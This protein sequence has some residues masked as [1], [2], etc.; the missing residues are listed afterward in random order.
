MAA[1]YRL[2]ATLLAAGQTEEARAHFAAAHRLVQSF[3]GLPAAA[4]TAIAHGNILRGLAECALA[5]RDPLAARIISFAALPSHQK[6]DDPALDGRTSMQRM[7]S[8]LLVLAGAELLLGR[9]EEAASFAG[10][11]SNTARTLLARDPDDAAA[12]HALARALLVVAEVSALLGD[13]RRAERA[14]LEARELWI[15]LVRFNRDNR[16]WRAALE[17]QLTTKVMPRPMQNQRRVKSVIV[18]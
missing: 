14:E 11:A 17:L 2:G 6:N 7:I 5:D 1:E 15:E 18:R 16:V 8:L 13:A 4:E 9:S 3:E 12:K 10:E